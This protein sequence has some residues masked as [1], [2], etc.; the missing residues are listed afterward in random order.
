[1]SQTTLSD[2]RTQIRFFHS[3]RGKLTLI[4][5]GLSLLP[6]IIAS[7]LAYW[8]SQQALYSRTEGELLRLT[9]TQAV[10]IDRWLDYRLAEAEVMANSEAMLSLDPVRMLQ[11][12]MLYQ[13]KWSQYE[14]IFVADLD[15]QALVNSNGD[16]INV[17]EKDCGQA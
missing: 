13:Q 9:K 14:M 5:L 7:G 16:A 11:A 10:A 1:M 6:L 4:F 3:L 12:V 8:Q 2:N 15:G 17:A